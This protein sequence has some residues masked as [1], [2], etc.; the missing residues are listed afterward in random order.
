MASAPLAA[1]GTTPPQARGEARV[2]ADGRLHL[3]VT[4]LP[5][6]PG[7][8]EVWLINPNTGAMFSV[9]VLGDSPDVLLPLPPR[10]DVREYSI[11]DISAEQFDNEPAHSGD[12]LVRGTLTG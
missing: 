12:S 7:Y 5:A 4:D 8:Y 6:V 11:V 1:Y 3:H 2:F 9:G 10:A